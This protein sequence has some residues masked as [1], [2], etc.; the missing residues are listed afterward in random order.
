MRDPEDPGAAN[1]RQ[2]QLR[3]TSNSF[4]T[5]NHEHLARYI[6]VR[7]HHSLGTS[8]LTC[9]GDVLTVRLDIIDST[10]T[11]RSLLAHS[12]SRSRRPSVSALRSVGLLFCGIRSGRMARVVSRYVAARC[13]VTF[14]LPICRG[15]PYESWTGFATNR[16]YLQTSRPSLCSQFLQRRRC[17]PQLVLAS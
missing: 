2:R 9:N 8:M 11:A 7:S 10:S 17:L 4:T 16:S 12:V 5:T 13:L 3:T 15:P 14:S 1:F 6:H